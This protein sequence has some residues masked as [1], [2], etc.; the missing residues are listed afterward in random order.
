M[1]KPI[2]DNMS[3]FKLTDIDEI[4]AR[5]LMY[6]VQDSINLNNITNEE[7]NLIYKLAGYDLLDSS[8]TRTL[9]MLYSSERI[10]WNEKKRN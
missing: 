1:R 4:K 7:H 5:D 9:V 8:T 10:E 2:G 6:K 3:V